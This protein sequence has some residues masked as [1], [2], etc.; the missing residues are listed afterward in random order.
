M[1]LLLS[2]PLLLALAACGPS[3]T[4]GAARA[5][6]GAG[7]D[8]MAPVPS[9]GDV[10]EAVDGLVVGHRLMAAGEYDLALKAYFRA[11]SE[12]GPSVDA[13]SAIGSANLRLGRVGQA[14]QVLR[15]ALDMD[16]TFVP[17]QNN[18]GVALSEQ[19]KWG[20]ASLHF[21]NA[22]A[23]DKGRSRE[24]RDNLRLAI[25]KTEKTGYVPDEANRLSLIRRGSGRYLLLSTPL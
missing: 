16:Q 8:Q 13:L 22:F 14:E 25:E 2:A 9:R 18:L 10:P 15:R 17:A 24:I 12:N 5:L 21:R 1:R 3:E 11:I 23:Y 4:D 20:E 19:G 7:P 6:A